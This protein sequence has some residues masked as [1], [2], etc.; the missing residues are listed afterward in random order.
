MILDVSRETN[1]QSAPDFEIFVSFGNGIELNP[2]L[3]LQFKDIAE[4]LNRKEAFRKIFHRFEYH[5][6]W[7][8]WHS[9]L[10]SMRRLFQLQRHILFSTAHPSFLCAHSYSNKAV[11]IL[12]FIIY[13]MKWNL[14]RW[15]HSGQ[16]AQY[17]KLYP[18]YRSS[19]KGKLFVSWVFRSES[20]LSKIVHS[21]SIAELSSVS[22]VSTPLLRNHF[23]TK[24]ISSP[25]D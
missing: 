21:K 2:V 1:E 25:D 4:M 8:S 11:I 23:H 14:M 10:G 12:L 7:P 22:T 3:Y 15:K 20:T 5:I 17:N 24:Y 19:S 13:S 9:V 6:K 18:D 16:W